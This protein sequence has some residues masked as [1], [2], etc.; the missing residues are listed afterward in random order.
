[1]LVAISD[2][3]S[4]ETPIFGFHR[5]EVVGEA[6]GEPDRGE[7]GRVVRP[8]IR[9]G[10]QPAHRRRVDD[11]ALGVLLEHAGHEAADRVHD[12]VEVDAEHPLPIAQRALPQQSAREDAGVVAQ[13]MRAAMVGERRVGQLLDRIGVGDIGDN[14]GRSAADALDELDR[15]GERRRFDV[16]RH[17]E[18]LFVREPPG[19]RATDAAAR[20]RDHCRLAR[21]LFHDDATLSLGGAGSPFA[22]S[23]R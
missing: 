3:T 2:G 20:A 14:G 23:V 18:H 12:A 19:E 22:G 10:E 8:R 5:A 15:L 21:E 6:L 1:M 7:L 13:H 17:D 4:T 11:V 16:G 9:V